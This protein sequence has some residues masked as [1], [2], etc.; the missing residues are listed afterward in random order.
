MSNRE[1]HNGCTE[2]ISDVLAKCFNI[3]TNS[4]NKE[5]LIAAI[6][7]IQFHLEFE[8]EEMEKRA[9]VHGKETREMATEIIELR[10]KVSELTS[11]I[12]YIHATHVGINIR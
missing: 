1:F 10:N 3:Y 7:R 11:Q 9:K 12:E 2:E 5:W 4:Y 8:K 6:K